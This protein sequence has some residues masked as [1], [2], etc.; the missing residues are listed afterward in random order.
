[1]ISTSDSDSSTLTRRGA[2]Q[3]V[4]I[5]L[6]A[7]L[8]LVTSSVVQSP[9][10]AEA[11]DVPI[12]FAPPGT[13]VIVLGGNGFVGSRVCAELQFAGAEVISVSRSGSKPA[14]SDNVKSIKGDPLVNDLTNIL[15]G[16]TAVVDCIGVI[17]T[18]DSILEKQNGDVNIAAIEQAKKAGVKRFVYVGVASA[19]GESLSSVLPGYFRGKSKAE[20]A[21][22]SAFGSAG[23]V[24]KPSFIYGGDSFSVNPPRVPDGYGGLVDGILGSGPLRA[25]ARVSPGF[26]GVALTN[27]VSVDVI[28][29][30]CV[31]G[32][33]GRTSGII[34]GTDSIVEAAKTAANA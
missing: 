2:L 15:K 18:D 22:I 17:G 8:A 5:Q 21:V 10:T 4:A 28:A 13:K 9:K 32:A 12:A 19:V 25:L 7:S 26:I 14:F 24:V 11:T 23:T 6:G 27:P 31:A 16:A 29:A 3:S 34:D 30:A 20:A 1:M 33:L